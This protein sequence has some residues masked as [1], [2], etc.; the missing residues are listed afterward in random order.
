MKTGLWFPPERARREF[1]FVG[2]TLSAFSVQLLIF[3]L[4]VLQIL[5]FYYCAT[6]YASL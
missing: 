1:A 3:S 6:V 4:D 2:L 5:G